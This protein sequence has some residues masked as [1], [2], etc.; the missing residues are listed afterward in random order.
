MGLLGCRPLKATYISHHLNA[1]ISEP[2]SGCL[3]LCLQKETST[4][5]ARRIQYQQ[6]E[7]ELRNVLPN[8][9]AVIA[10]SW[11]R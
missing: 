2:S 8:T 6:T 4:V 9:V 7:Q 3:G 10:A 11:Q 1:L 5:E